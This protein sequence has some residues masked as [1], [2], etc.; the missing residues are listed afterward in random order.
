MVLKGYTSPM[1]VTFDGARKESN[2]GILQ[3]KLVAST[4]SH[5]T[6]NF[7]TNTY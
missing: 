2:L 4:W 6:N 3:A 7:A 5:L 1:A